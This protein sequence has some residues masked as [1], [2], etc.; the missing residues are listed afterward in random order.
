LAGA[1][2]GSGAVWGLLGGGAHLGSTTP[3]HVDLAVAF[4]GEFVFTAL[5]VIAVF[6]LSDLG[7]G[8]R[9]WR[10]TLP[11]LA[12]ALS[13]LVIGPW[14]GSSLNPARTLAP[15]ILSGTYTDLWLYLIAVP[16]GSLAVAAVWRPRAV[17][18]FDRGPGRADVSR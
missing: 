7:E 9:R 10:L 2:I 5:L 14:T 3:T 8:R 17:D 16:L 13:T 18:I 11:P 6:A 1:F 15:A 12:V 4:V